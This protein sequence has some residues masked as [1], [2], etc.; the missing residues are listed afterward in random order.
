MTQNFVA[1]LR[2]ELPPLARLDSCI[3]RT[4]RHA[5]TPNFVIETTRQGRAQTRIPAD[6]AICENCLDDLFDPSSRFHHYPFVNCTHCGPRYTLTRNLPYDR[7]QTSMARF[8]MCEECARDYADPTNRRFHAEP[9]ACAKCGP[10]LSHPPSEIVAALRA[11]KIVALKGI[12]GFH[13]LC[14]A[15]NADA[16]AELRRR[17]DREAKPFALMLANEASAT[18]FGQPTPRRTGAV[19]FARASHRADRFPAAICPKRSRPTWRA[20]A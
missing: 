1:T 9:I 7:A 5:A 20:S 17:K 13:L 11:G 14:D 10:R 2:A 16:V 4:S 8:P 6:A 12:G 19:A 15:R 18:L 3:A